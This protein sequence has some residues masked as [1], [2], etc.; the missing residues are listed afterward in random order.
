MDPLI[1]IIVVLL[2]LWLGGFAFSIGGGLIHILLVIALVVIVVRLL[3]GPEGPLIS[4]NEIRG[5]PRRVNS[6]T[7]D[8]GT[9]RAR[10]LRILPSGII[11]S[12]RPLEGGCTRSA[13]RANDQRATIRNSLL[14]TGF[15]HVP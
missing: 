1:I 6:R 9:L 4:I 13:V 8:D 14:R 5:R 11:R 3:A 2:V 7:T 15:G 12:R 10:G